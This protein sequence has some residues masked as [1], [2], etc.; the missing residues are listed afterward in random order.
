MPQEAEALKQDPS[1]IEP[2]PKAPNGFRVIQHFD[3]FEAEARNWTLLK[4]GPISVSQH[5]AWLRTSAEFLGREQQLHCF[6]VGGLQP[7][8]T[9]PLMCNRSF[10]G[11]LE[12]L[13]PE[14]LLGPTDF[15][16]SGPSTLKE[17]VDVLVA[18]KRPLLLKRVLADSPVVAALQSGFRGRALIRITPVAGY[19]W[20]P[21][22]ASCTEPDPGL[23]EPARR[24]A[25]ALGVLSFEI[26]CP[27]HFELEALMHEV[28]SIG[29]TPQDECAFFTRY[30]EATA[31]S[32]ELR[33]CFMRIDARCVAAI[34]AVDVGARLWL[35]KSASDA[36]FNDCLPERL[37]LQE[38]VRYAAHAGRR[39]IE[40]LGVDGPCVRAWTQD[41]RK[42]VSVAVYPANL[43][44]LT[45][46]AADAVGLI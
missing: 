29:A 44:G 35:L 31:R 41:V 25:E 3:S 12:S 14:G 4:Q 13:S 8:A 24:R 28:F 22:Q 6:A 17:I 5:Y 33:L 38:V 20:L 15:P 16:H 40:F 18:A 7:A 26:H 32:G 42:C 27:T 19:P 21:L 10:P 2:A 39:S 46:L 34:F 45:A 30:A 23:T 36:R 1:A 43:R 11:R 37:L 9:A